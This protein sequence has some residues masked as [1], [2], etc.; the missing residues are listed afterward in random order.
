M[1]CLRQ[2]S[3]LREHTWGVEDFLFASAGTLYPG[4][5]SSVSYGHLKCGGGG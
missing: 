1:F 5:E 2:P 4:R 3:G